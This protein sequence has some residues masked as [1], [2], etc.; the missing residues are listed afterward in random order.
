[1]VQEYLGFYRMT[2]SNTLPATR[3]YND[4]LLNVLYTHYRAVHNRISAL[5]TFLYTIVFFIRKGRDCFRAKKKKT[6]VLIII[7]T[8]QIGELVSY[9]LSVGHRTNVMNNVVV[10]KSYNSA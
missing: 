6:D 2:T 5:N 3:T 9:R 10:T 8:N 1:M 7:H 4:E